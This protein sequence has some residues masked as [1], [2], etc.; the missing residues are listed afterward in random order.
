MCFW[1]YMKNHENMK[2]L[3][4]K[5]SYFRD[6]MNAFVVVFY[7][8]ALLSFMILIATMAVDMNKYKYKQFG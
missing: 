3:G 5:R 7:F 6:L 8:A 2:G 1:Y 4:A